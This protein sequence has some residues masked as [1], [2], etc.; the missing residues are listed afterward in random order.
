[1]SD[2]IK[3]FDEKKWKEELDEFGYLHD[4]DCCV[5]FPEDAR[6]CDVSVETLDCCEN[7][8]TIKTIIEKVIL[9]R[10]R[11]WSEMIKARRKYAKSDENKVLT[12]V[13]RDIIK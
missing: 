5:N 11:F 13:K 6:A 10:D 2:I 8:K 3:Y 9:D 4:E 7:M 1:M 12:K